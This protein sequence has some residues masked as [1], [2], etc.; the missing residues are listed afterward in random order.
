MSSGSRRGIK[1]KYKRCKRCKELV[2]D[3]INCANCANQNPL[4]LT[5]RSVYPGKKPSSS[6]DRQEGNSE[7]YF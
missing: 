3:P 5:A 6:L 1:H 4:S 7:E 2:L